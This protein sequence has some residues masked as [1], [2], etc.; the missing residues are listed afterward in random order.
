MDTEKIVKA[1]KEEREKLDRAIGVLESGSSGSRGRG[2]DKPRSRGC[3]RRINYGRNA[4]NFCRA[5]RYSSTG[6]RCWPPRKSRRRV[7]RH[8]EPRECSKWPEKAT[9]YERGSA[10]RDRGGAKTRSLSPGPV[11]KLSIALPLVRG[12]HS[13]TPKKAGCNY[14]KNGSLR[15]VKRSTTLIA[16]D[17]LHLVSN[18]I[19]LKYELTYLVAFGSP[20]TVIVEE[21]KNRKADLIVV[22][23]RGAG[24][25]ASRKPAL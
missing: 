20:E 16:E 18:G 7:P 17:I 24:A 11:S 12:N 3:C 19:D 15:E 4:T 1:L 8:R 2:S 22:G 25:M 23:A 6:P 13:G 9:A 21:A 5:I 14:V 10:G